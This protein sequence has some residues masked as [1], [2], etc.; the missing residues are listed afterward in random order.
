MII[1]IVQRLRIK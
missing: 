1:L